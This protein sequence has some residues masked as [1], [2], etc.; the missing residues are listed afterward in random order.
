MSK[1]YKENYRKIWEKHFGKIPVDENGRSYDIHH[2]DGNKSNNN[3]ENL[4][5][6]SIKDHFDIH[7]KQGDFNACNAI[8]LRMTNTNFKHYRHSE[9]TKRKIKQSLS[10][11]GQNHSSKKHE[12]RAKISQS[13]KGKNNNNYEKYG[14]LHHNFGKK[15]K[16]T[17]EQ[18]NNRRGHNNKSSKKIY[19]YSE[20]LILIKEWS[21]IKEAATYYNIH[22]SSIINAIKRSNKCRG[23]IWRY[24]TLD[25]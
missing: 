15:W 3:V 6:V 14:A 1:G 5:A 22:S 21:T 20:N 18:A 24:T 23:F 12:V 25:K 2:L 7:F 4:I 19:Q 16:L 17:E 8:S 13:L 11:K 10:S 9:E